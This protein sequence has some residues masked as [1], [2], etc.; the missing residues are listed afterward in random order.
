MYDIHSN[1]WR[2]HIPFHYAFFKDAGA[3][4]SAFP[5]G[6]FGIHSWTDDPGFRLQE[7]R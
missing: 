4:Y 1:V 2:L 7:T 3:R 6:T 5:S